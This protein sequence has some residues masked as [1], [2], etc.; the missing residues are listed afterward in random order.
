MPMPFAYRHATDEF[1]AYLAA[2][3]E[4]TLIE[5]DNV[6]YTATDAVF[7]SF[8]A[9]VTAAQALH[10]A[11]ELPAV[12]RAIFVWRWDIGAPTLPWADRDTIRAE[13]TGLRRDHNFCPPEILEDVLAA[14]RR[15]CRERDIDRVLSEIGP[16][17]VAFWAT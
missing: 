7:R 8:R 2:L 14:V 10:F 15:A 16:E 11:D 5:S 12:L 4:Q 13:M 17:A 3:R 1:R 6:I 9:R